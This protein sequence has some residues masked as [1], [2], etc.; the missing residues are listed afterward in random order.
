[1]LVAAAARSCRLWPLRGG[2]MAAGTPCYRAL[3]FL[4]LDLGNHDLGPCGRFG[5]SARL[6]F[7]FQTRL[8]D[9]SLLGLAILFGAAPLILALLTAL[10][11]VA[12]ASFFERRKTSF[13]GF[14]K[15]PS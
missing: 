2:R 15:K 10:A 12:A 8:F 6:F 1:M 14:A 5:G 13:L 9:R 3:L 11:F 4:F 7:G